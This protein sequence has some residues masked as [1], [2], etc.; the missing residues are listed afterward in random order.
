MP[1]FRLAD[2][3]LYAIGN[4]RDTPAGHVTATAID[5]LG[6]LRTFLWAGSQP[7]DDHYVGSIIHTATSNIA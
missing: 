1:Q 4:D 5:P 2:L 7:D 6:N 3:D